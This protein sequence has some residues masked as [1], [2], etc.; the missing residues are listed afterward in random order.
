MDGALWMYAV[1]ALATALPLL[2][3]SA[4]LA[5]A[6]ALAAVGRLQLSLVL[7][8][9]LAGAIAGDLAVYWAGTRARGRVLGWVVRNPRRR[10]AMGW[11]ASRVGRH[12][13]PAVIAMRFVPSGRFVGGLTTGIVGFGRRRYLLGAGVAELI[14]VSYTVG[15]G[16]TGGL[17]AASSG[18]ALIIGPGVSLLVAGVAAAAQGMSCRRAARVRR[19][20]AAV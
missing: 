20:S 9:P 8:V 15:L 7:L 1:L 16:Y 17:V 3:N 11:A 12:G 19:V 5:G 13:V 18:S 14:F 2:P 4:I 10:A 6:G